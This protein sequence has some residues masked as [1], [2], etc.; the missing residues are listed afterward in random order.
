MTTL[1]VLTV[2]ALAVLI[3]LKRAKILSYFKS[4]DVTLNDR[5]DDAAD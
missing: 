5:D 3:Y 4:H 1:L 2:L